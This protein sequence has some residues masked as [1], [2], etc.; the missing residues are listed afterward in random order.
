MRSL[1][2]TG[3]TPSDRDST[4][5]QNPLR[6]APSLLSCD[7]ARICDEVNRVEAAGGDWHH[8]DV[9]DGHFVPNLTIGPAVVQRIADCAGI[10]L[11]VH[12]MISEPARYAEVFAKAGAGFLTFHAE[13]C[14]DAGALRRTLDVFRAQEQ[15]GV[16]GVGIALN[17]DTDLRRIEGVLDGIDMVLVMSVFPGFG[18]QTFIAEVLKKVEALRAGGFSKRIEMDG[19]LNLETLPLCVAAGAD[20]LVAG[21]AIYGAGDMQGRIEELRRRGEKARRSAEQ[22]ADEGRGVSGSEL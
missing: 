21:S 15:H 8:L 5:S 3:N 18:G 12:L 16:Q 14:P 6:I 1:T 4:V 11:D 9:M 10:P 20:T 7:F 17:P 2:L 13:V 22:D 19:G